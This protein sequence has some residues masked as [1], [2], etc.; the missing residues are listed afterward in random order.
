MNK[1]RREKL[2]AANAL[3][4]KASD[5]IFNVVDEETDALDNTPE[6]LQSS[7]AYYK[8]EEIIDS[9]EDAISDISQ[10]STQITSVIDA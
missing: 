8:R 1:R 2:N 9:L 6:N 3:L 10:A 4:E 5:I 7:D